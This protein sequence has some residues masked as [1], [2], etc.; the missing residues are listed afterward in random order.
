MAKRTKKK[1]S[2]KPAKQPTR[3]S[4]SR[5]K[6]LLRWPV[7]IGLLVLVCLLLG[8]WLAQERRYEK[9]AVPA[10]EEERNNRFGELVSEV[11]LIIYQSLRQLGV[12]AS[13]VQFRKVI[14]RVQHNRQWDFTELEITLPQEQ[15]LAD[16]Y[17][18]FTK[19]FEA[20]KEKVTLEGS[21]DRGPDLEL[22]IRVDGSLTHRLAFFQG[23]KQALQ[24]AQP[25]PV[26]KV[27]IVIDDLGYDG[28][29]AKRF[30]K[31]DGPLSFS[32]LPHGTFS[33]SIARR[34]H[35]ADQEL[36]LH[37]P[38][39]PTGYPKVNPGVG[40][41]LVEMTEV[42]LVQTLREDLDA[43]PYI[44]GVN[45]HMGSKFCQN[46][47][48]LRP[49]MLELNTRGLFFLDSR[50]T[51]KTKA[52]TVAQ[53]LHV[54]SAERNVFLDNIQNPRAIRAQLNRLI[55]LARLKG[56][57]IGIA[58]PHKVTLEVLRREIPKLSGKGVELVPV[59]Q[60]V[61]N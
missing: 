2:A 53:E 31:I 15:S 26:P 20:L 32:V 42:E 30:L 3:K 49:V 37:L 56:G 60:L 34:I 21:K 29:L 57:A 16:I 50:T 10:Y 9:A 7:G 28:R 1:Q 6:L 58:H 35:D 11:E 48:K 52:Y 44:K 51:S 25:T 55:E 54:P 33:K 5:K 46:E 18:L 8:L 39:E 59:S 38:M 45:N 61:H 27:A 17:T 47:R 40:A 36:L 24:K 4:P 12:H 19:N 23:P 13:Q 41:L 22:L 14:H 43:F